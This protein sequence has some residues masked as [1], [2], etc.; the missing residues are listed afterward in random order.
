MSIGWSVNCIGPSLNLIKKNVPQSNFTGPN[1]GNVVTV[2]VFGKEG[3]NTTVVCEDPLENTHKSSSWHVPSRPF[4]GRSTGFLCEL[5]SGLNNCR[6]LANDRCGVNVASLCE[7]GWIWTGSCFAIL[8][9]HTARQVHGSGSVA[10]SV[11]IR[12]LLKLYLQSIYGRRHQS[13]IVISIWVFISHHAY[14]TRIV[15]RYQSILH[16]SKFEV[17]TVWNSL[18]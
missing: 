6:D 7:R 8:P 9:S 1:S 2:T 3:T 4:R 14:S 16:L 18:N 5:H 10:I 12:V 17:S 15:W 11:S 13:D